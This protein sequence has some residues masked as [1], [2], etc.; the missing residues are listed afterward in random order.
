M[1]L[2]SYFDSPMTIEADEFLKDGQKITLAGINMTFIATPG[3]TPGSGCYYLEDNEILFSGD[4]LFH[5]SR[6]RT[7]FPGGSESEI[8]KSIRE[9]LLKK[10][11]SIMVDWFTYDGEDDDCYL[12]Y[13]KDWGTLYYPEVHLVPTQQSATTTLHMDTLCLVQRYLLHTTSSSTTITKI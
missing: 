11:K 6:G 13:N 1:N 2:S 5:G 12:I 4:T 10:L 3:H 8:M 9:K 7:D